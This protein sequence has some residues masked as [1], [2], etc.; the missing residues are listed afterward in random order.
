MRLGESLVRAGVLSEDRLAIALRLQEELRP[1]FGVVAAAQ[2]FLPA[3]EIPR[4]LERQ[5]KSERRFGEAA[6]DLG[7]LDA[8]R[9][10]AVLARQAEARASSRLGQLLVAM[11]A[12]PPD[13]LTRELQRARQAPPQD[14]PSLLKVVEAGDLDDT[15]MAVL[16]F[17]AEVVPSDFGLVGILHEE[18]DSLRLKW[19]LHGEEMSPEL[20]RQRAKDGFFTIPLKGGNHGG[21]FKHVVKTRQP[22]LTG[23]VTSPDERHYLEAWRES[24]SNVTVPLLAHEGDLVGVLGLE[25]RRRNAYGPEDVKQLQRL[26]GIAAVA[27]RRAQQSAHKDKEVALFRETARTIQNLER[28]VIT[29]EGTRRALD[30]VLDICLEETGCRNGFISLVNQETGQLDVVIIKGDGMLPED[31][32]PAS[33]PPGR[34]VT[35]TVA[36]TGRPLLVPDVEAQPNFVRFFENIRSELAVPLSYEGKVIGVI[37]VESRKPGHFTEEKQRYFQTLADLYAPIVHSAQ[38]YEFTRKKFGEGIR[39]IGEAG[40]VRRIR[41]IFI[42]AARSEAN[43]LLQGESGTGKEYLA[44]IV[45]FNSRRAAGA[46]EVVDCANGQPELIESDLFGHVKGAFTGAVADKAG[47]FELADGGTIFL[48]EI[49]DLRLDLQGKILR[50]LQE[51]TF[52]RVGE[53]RTR[54]VNVRVIAAT[55]KDL[56]ALVAARQFRDDLLFRLDQVTL[57]LPPLRERREDIGPL[58]EHFLWKY[59]TRERRPAA[60]GIDDDALAILWRQEWRGNLRELEHFV[61]KLVIFG[62]GETIRAGDVERVAQLFNIALIEKIPKNRPEPEVRREMAM[63]LRTTHARA[64]GFNQKRAAALLNWDKATLRSKMRRQ[65]APETEGEALGAEAT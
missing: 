61:Y 32:R 58:V 25:S 12:V 43:L 50:V 34:G 30:Q 10:E 14:F 4:V 49:G 2:G 33:L 17:A 46:F 53:A 63:A 16:R 52:R 57:R 65:R 35:G 27:I 18:S 6:V 42:K 64:G 1:R 3:S 44:K 41:N 19:F 29:T 13:A 56:R 11:G 39:F 15:I 40:A 31:Q 38:F 48:D 62:E 28:S 20:L 59:S 22:Y 37:N 26:A 7:L 21:I 51:G 55:N 47:L 9:V 36:L 45:H 54:R 5:A 23:D 8:R 24:R 60:I